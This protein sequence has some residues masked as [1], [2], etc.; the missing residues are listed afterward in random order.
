MEDFVKRW[1][2]TPLQKGIMTAVLELGALVGALFAGYFAD[3][4]SRRY[5]II[6]AC[7]IFSI[8][9]TFQALA[10]NLFHL[11][12]GRAIG[13]IGVGAL[14]ML[15]PLYM[16]EISPPEVRG[17]LL[18]L[19]QLSIVLGVVFG[20]WTGFITRSIPGPMSWRI[21]LGV[22]II[23]GIILGLG[24]LIL[25]PSPRW[26][27]LK[28]RDADA[29][30]S[31]ARLRMRTQ[32][33]SESDSLLQIELLEMKVETEL[34][35]KTF[36]MDG[37]KSGF[38]T[39]L[40]A[41][42]R[43]FSKEYRDRTLVGVLIMFFQ[44]WSG[45]NALLYYGPTLVQ[46]IGLEGDTVSLLVSGGIG[47]VQFFAV[48]PAIVYIDK[49]GRKPLMR[50]GSSVMSASHMSIAL[51]VLLFQDDWASHRYAAW[52]AVGG[53]YTFT[54]AYGVSFGPIGW[55]LPSE[56]FPLS[57]RSK[58]VAL[59]TAS[60]WANNFLIGLLTPVIISKSPSATFV[61]FSAACFL[62]Y[63]WATYSVPETANVSLEEMDEV[64]NSAAG[65]E[66]SHIKAQIEED[67]G[68]KALIEDLANDR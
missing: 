13:G 21:P 31:L 7:I 55:V 12:L 2:I 27:V 62:A 25:P 9:S 56:V 44:Q 51:L 40:R 1:P 39:E 20:F 37:D 10:Q 48:I 57:M 59:S 22:Q 47:I 63:L 26:L 53:I 29:L 65:K 24:C 6:F 50:L 67:L 28:G 38:K 45:I 42:G 66:D 36:A 61:T 52:I 43:L 8:G 54:A 16:A 46:S 30:K 3:K 14:S 18:A 19:E 5:S 58:G 15:S 35:Q 11:F 33:E 41:W 4:Y 23:P 17:S 34:I 49:I 32:E 60:N 64:F 68:L